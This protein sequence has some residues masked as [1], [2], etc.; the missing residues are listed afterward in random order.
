MI[1]LFEEQ[2]ELV[3]LGLTQRREV[4][5]GEG[6]EHQIGFH[7][8]AAPGAVFQLAATSVHQSFRCGGADIGANAAA[9]Q[10]FEELAVYS[11]QSLI[12]ISM[13]VRRA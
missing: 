10:R 6:A 12:G 1:R 5:V 11:D 8:A 2:L 7:E 13:G 3:E 9:R 4:R